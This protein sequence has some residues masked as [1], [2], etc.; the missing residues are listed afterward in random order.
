MKLNFPKWCITM[1]ARTLQQLNYR[2]IYQAAFQKYRFQCRGQKLSQPSPVLI[3]QLNKVNVSTQKQGWIWHTVGQAYTLLPPDTKV[4]VWKLLERVRNVS[5][6]SSRA[7]RRDSQLCVT[8]LPEQW[9][10]APAA[11]NM[12]LHLMSG[13]AFLLFSGRPYLPTNTDIQ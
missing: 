13:S 4:E 10:A 8:L 9:Q 11:L 2:V 12:L 6:C 1:Q 3:T 5:G 7:W